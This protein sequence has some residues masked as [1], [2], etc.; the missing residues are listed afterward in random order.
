MQ[1]VSLGINRREFVLSSMMFGLA[2]CA[3]TSPSTLPPEGSEIYSESIETALADPSGRNF[4]SVRLCQYPK[5]GVAW[6]WAAVYLDG[7]FWKFEN[8][9]VRWAGEPSVEPEAQHAEYAARV[10]TTQVRYVRNGANQTPTNGKMTFASK[11]N[12]GIEIEVVFSPATQFVGLIPGRTEA[13]GRSVAK[14][15]TGGQDVTFAGPGKWHE[16]QQT[17]SRFTV[18]FVY[19][20][21]W[22]DNV[23][24]T[25]LQTPQGS[26]GYFIQN[27]TVTVFS[28][29]QFAP[30]AETRWVHLS[31]PDGSATGLELKEVHHYFLTIY[32]K[33]WRGSLV[34]ANILG[35]PVCGYANNWLL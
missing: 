22:G 10:G 24:S 30:P 6:I 8:N 26:G 4:L 32:R 1:S 5:A 15:R 23:F 13:F 9:A 17:E 11:E 16:Q 20:S 33:P 28:D 7:K 19:A 14:V 3:T 29:A 25:L 31:G 12:G 27:D 35:T 2:G 18:P 34:T 21:L